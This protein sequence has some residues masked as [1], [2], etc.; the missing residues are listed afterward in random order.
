MAPGAPGPPPG[1][2]GSPGLPGSPAAFGG[3]VVPSVEMLRRPSAAC[4]TVTAGLSSTM[5][6]SS[7]RPVRSGSS[8]RRMRPVLSLRKG[9]APNFGSS[10][11]SR[12][13]SSTAGS[14][15]TRSETEAN[16]TGRPSVWVAVLAM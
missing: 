16:F 14:G 4:T 1:R 6:P 9:V 11:T 15:S 13:C 2:D 7:T 3:G 5:S 10:A 8:C 12:S